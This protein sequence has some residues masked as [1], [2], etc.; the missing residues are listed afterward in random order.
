MALLIREPFLLP[1]LLKSVPMSDHERAHENAQPATTGGAKKRFN[2]TIGI[3]ILGALGG[4]V[5]LWGAISG[6]LETS[7][8]NA[9]KAAVISNQ[10]A[11]TVDW[12]GRAIAALQEETKQI[13]Q[14]QA[15]EHQLS[16]DTKQEVDDLHKSVF[17][18]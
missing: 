8:Q 6:N 7:K 10:V 11:Q 12:H 9:I 17:G 13:R 5:T 15:A 2:W 16:I 18:K 14:D 3:M 1:P 4:P